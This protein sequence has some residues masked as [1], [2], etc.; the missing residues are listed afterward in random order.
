M[1]RYVSTNR[2]NFVIKKFV[3]KFRT[4]SIFVALEFV[5]VNEKNK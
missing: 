4:N 1:L 2:T 3:K 5:F